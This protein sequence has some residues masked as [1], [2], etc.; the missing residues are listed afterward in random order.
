V[1]E[2]G[3][4]RLLLMG[5]EEHTKLF[6]GYLPKRL[7]EKVVAELPSLPHPGASPG[8]VL[9]RLEPVLEEVERQA[10]VRLLEEAGGG[11]PQGGLRPRGP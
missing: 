6:L 8:E 3:F 11:L 9:K 2:R 10:E 4:T 7:K 5:P 1:E